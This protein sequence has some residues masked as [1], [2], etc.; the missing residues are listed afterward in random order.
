MDSRAELFHSIQVR[1]L[2]PIVP[3]QTIIRIE[4]GPRVILLIMI[5]SRKDGECRQSLTFAFLM[6]RLSRSEV[7]SDFDLSFPSL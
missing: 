6:Q 1:F 2:H 5:K 3:L 4:K 7:S